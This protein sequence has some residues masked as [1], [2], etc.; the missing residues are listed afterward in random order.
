MLWW[1]VPKN[2]YKQVFLSWKGKRGPFC[3]LSFL[4]ILCPVLSFP[5]PIKLPIFQFIIVTIRNTLSFSSCPYI[6]VFPLYYTS[7]LPL[8]S[9]SWTKLY[10]LVS[11]LLL[12]FHWPLPNCFPPSLALWACVPATSFP[13]PPC[14][15]ISI[16]VRHN[17]FLSWSHSRSTQR[18]SWISC[19]HV[20]I[21]I[22]ELQKV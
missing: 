9:K 5:F 4:Q 19:R 18:A 15:T 13:Q 16:E 21:K 12:S 3:T 22:T 6:S 11:T 17:V 7:S 8:V 2:V 1:W 14:I 20:N 10:V